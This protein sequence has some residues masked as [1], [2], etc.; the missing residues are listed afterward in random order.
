MP[1]GVPPSPVFHSQFIYVPCALFHVPGG[2]SLQ[3][4]TFVFNHFHDAPLTTPFFSNFCIVVR[5]CTPFSHSATSRGCE[6]C[7]VSGSEQGESI[8]DSDLVAKAPHRHPRRF[9]FHRS[10]AQRLHFE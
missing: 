3:I 4:C 2:L 7:K 5:G 8:A 9:S 10:P 6:S 1:G